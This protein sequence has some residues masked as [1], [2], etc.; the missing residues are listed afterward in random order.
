MT[1][2]SSRSTYYF[3]G[4]LYPVEFCSKFN[5]QETNIGD[6]MILEVFWDGIAIWVAGTKKDFNLLRPKVGEAFELVIAAFILI[7][8]VK[9]GLTLQSWV[10]AKNC[11]SKNNV[12]G[13]IIPPGSKLPS[14]S[15]KSKSSLAWKKAGKYYSNISKSFYHRLA[16]KDFKTCVSTYGDDAF[17]YAYRII[18]DIRRAAT[19]HMPD[20]LETKEYWNEMHKK[21]GTS[22]AQIDPLTKISEAIRHGDLNNSVLKHARK[23]REKMLNIATSILKAEFKIAFKG[24]LN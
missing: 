23:N 11:V 22:K 10:Q 18:E 2:Q 1:N 7:T 12:I 5:L 4:R 19:S 24:F 3:I 16:L 6:G 13:F 9:I 21:L 14:P 20:G 8:N 15:Q 17:F